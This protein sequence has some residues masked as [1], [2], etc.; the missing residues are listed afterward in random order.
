M[1]LAG[2][3]C[4]LT[5]SAG[6]IQNKL[7]LIGSLDFGM[8]RHGRGSDSL[9]ALVGGG[10]NGDR[11]LQNALAVFEFI[12]NS[13]DRRVSMP[14]A[15]APRHLESAFLGSEDFGQIQ[16]RAPE[17]VGLRRPEPKKRGEAVAQDKNGDARANFVHVMLMKPANK[18]QQANDER[19]GGQKKARSQKN[20]LKS[21]GP[22]KRFQTTKLFAATFELFSVVAQ[23]PAAG[24]P[25]SVA[26]GGKASE[27]EKFCSHVRSK[28]VRWKSEQRATCPRRVFRG[29]EIAPSRRRKEA[30]ARGPWKIFCRRSMHPM[31]C[32]R[33]R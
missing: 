18:K 22:R 1:R 13:P 2:G 3:G 15:I 6:A 33:K 25:G 20:R 27:S 4:A 26:K 28:S 9:A 32:S 12:P 7:R 30:G 21:E 11:V 5:L 19:P 23:T 17:Q 10:M 16:M 29:K 31:D 8:A 24:A 14:S